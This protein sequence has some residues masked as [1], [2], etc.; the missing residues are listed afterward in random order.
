M[1]IA[2]V[3]A[4]EVDGGSSSG[5]TGTQ[6]VTWTTSNLVTGNTIALVTYWAGNQG[7]TGT[8]VTDSAGNTYTMTPSYNATSQLN[9]AIA[10]ASITAGGGT[11]PTITIHY[12]GTSAAYASIRAYEFSGL[13]T[14]L[15]G[16][17]KTLSGTGTAPSPGSI[18]TTNA[19]DLLI[20]AAMVDNAVT[21][22]PA[23][24]TTTLDSNGSAYSYNIV[25]STGTYTPTFVHNASA[26]WNT[27]FF[28]LKNATSGTTQQGSVSSGMGRSMT[29][30][31]KN[32][33]HATVII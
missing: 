26:N 10:Y 14:T 5:S 3:Q 27:I 12:T 1:A 25:T 31:A 19:N 20:A 18:T 11:K 13:S 21:S 4:C 9:L 16:T 17:V 6:T 29:L 2:F 7:L 28:A 8:P 23:G 15:D 32:N 22:G 24:W 30:S 33:A